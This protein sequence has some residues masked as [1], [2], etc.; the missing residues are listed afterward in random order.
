VDQIRGRR[1]T[2]GIDGVGQ[3]EGSTDA[4]LLDIGTV[5]AELSRGV[6]LLPGD[7]IALGPASQAV[8]VPASPRL[9]AATRVT[10]SIEGIGEVNAVLV[11]QRKSTGS[12]SPTVAKPQP[13]IAPTARK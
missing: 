8:V 3:V 13:T 2:F 12:E 11:D 4:Y 1:T 7:V 10:A 6:T 5:V 9:A